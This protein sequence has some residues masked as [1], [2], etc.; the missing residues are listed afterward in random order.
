MSRCNRS[1]ASQPPLRVSEMG[2]GDAGWVLDRS[3]R[4]AAGSS[5]DVRLEAM[6]FVGNH[7]GS[8]ASVACTEHGLDLTLPEGFRP[9]SRSV[10]GD[11][12]EADR[13]FVSRGRWRRPVQVAGRR[14][15]ARPSKAS[16]S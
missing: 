11:Y 4:P 7:D 13:V 6:L 15:S 10:D 9:S 2:P 1:S 12:V 3:I 16:S 8:K 14:T 5:V